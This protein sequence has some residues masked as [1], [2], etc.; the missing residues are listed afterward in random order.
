LDATDAS[1]DSDG[2]GS[3]NFEEYQGGTDP[4][5]AEFKGLPPEVS[6]LWILGAAIAIIAIAAALTF[7]WR[8][9]K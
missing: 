2:D 9:R 3:T 7:L 6:P 1:L 5:V 4:N 8:R